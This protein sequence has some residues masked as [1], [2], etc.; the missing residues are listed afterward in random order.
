MEPCFAGADRELSGAIERAVTLYGGPY[1]LGAPTNGGPFKPALC[2]KAGRRSPM[3]DNV[4]VLVARVSVAPCAAAILMALAAP[5]AAQNEDALR[6]FFEGKRVALKI[7]MPG[8]SDGV[9]VRPDAGRALDYRQYGD[10]LKTYG[11]ALRAGDSAAVTLVKVKKDLIEVQLSGGGF[12]TFRDDSSSSV[13]IPSVQKSDREKELE[14]SVREETDPRRKRELREQLEDVRN[15]RE[16]ENRAIDVERI[17]A[18][19]RKKERIAW[20]RLHGGSRFNLRYSGAVPAGIRPEEVM[21]ALAEYV[22]FS[23]AG[24][25]T[26]TEDFLPAAAADSRLSPG[27]LPRKGMTRAEAEREFGSPTEVSDH[28]EGGLAVTTLVFVRDEQ[29]IATEFVEDVMVRYTIT[30]K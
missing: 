14:K 3:L 17:W 22:D 2:Q 12:G 16:R 9:D 30:S 5:A 20:E 26:R 21:A 6:S 7:D 4:C 19:E 11:V 29:R 13:S 27:N 10:R 24:L 23:A 8:T 28:R 1:F 25:E 18:E 15:R